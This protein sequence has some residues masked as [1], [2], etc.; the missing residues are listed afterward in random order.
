MRNGH[1]TYVEK[2]FRPDTMATIDFCNDVITEYQAQGFTLTLRQLYYQLVARD[3]IPNNTKSYKRLVSV[4]TDA[5]R[6]GLVSWLAIEDRTR[7]VRSQTHWNNPR[8]IA[9][10]AVDSYYTDHW[11]GQEFQPIVLIEKDALVGVISGVC[12]RLD[13]PY[14]ST[15]GYCSDPEVWALAQKMEGQVNSNQ[16]PLVIHLADHD[17]SGI[18]MSRD[19]QG[20][21]E[22]FGIYPM[23]TRLALNMDQVDQYGPPPNFAKITDSRADGYIA[24]YGRNSWELDALEPSVI[25]ALIEYTILSYRDDDIYDEV[26]ARQEAE[27]ERLRE[28]ARQLR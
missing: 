20:R 10:A 12:S 9:M 11:E 7:N 24:E 15:R 8:E 1:I 27:R 16:V 23:F 21:L 19:L 14:L 6:A 2:N 17:P 26:V 4:I 5:R 13:V 22:M 18:D 28:M 3:Y 25:A